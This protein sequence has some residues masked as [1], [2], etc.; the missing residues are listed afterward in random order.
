MIALIPLL[1]LVAA[2]GTGLMAGLFFAFSSFIMAALARLPAEQGIAAMNSINVT[3]LNATFGLAFFGTAALCVVLGIVSILYWPAPG[4]AWLLAGSLL[5]L[6]GTIAVTMVFNVPL[7]D[8]LAAIAPASQEGAALWTRYFAEWLPWNHVRTL[9]NI[10]A[11]IA[12]ISAHARQ[13]AL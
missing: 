3:I 6:V 11:L 13:A 7:N 10:A 2:L 12:F 4:S 1:T 5:Y 8:A 9:A